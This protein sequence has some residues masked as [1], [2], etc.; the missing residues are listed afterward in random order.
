MTIALC[1]LAVAIWLSGGSRL[2]NFAMGRQEG[3]ARNWLM[4]ERGSVGG[5]ALGRGTPGWRR[6]L[7][8]RQLRWIGAGAALAAAV[9][10]LGPVRG[11]VLGA[12]VAPPTS[13]A[14]G[15]LHGHQR[16]R[17]RSLEMRR[18]PLV[19]DLV[20]ASLR[21]GQPVPAALAAVAPVAG[22]ELG[23]QLHHVAGLLRLGAE[24]ASAWATLSEPSLA[25]VIATACRSA[26]SGVRLARGF[27]RLAAELRDEA[28]ATAIARAHRAGVWAMAPLGLCFLPA[29]ACLGILPVIIGIAHGVLHGPAP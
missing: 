5:V 29:F 7:T 15:W 22:G 28:R 6:S 18:V 26:E 4:A 20:A 27:E 16:V 21:G 17:S 1:W 13:V 25:P 24:P 23:D 8:A 10:L 9:I 14:I 2:R 19:L 3:R 11:G 12:L